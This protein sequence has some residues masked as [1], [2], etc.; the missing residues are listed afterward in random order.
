M[1]PVLR[2]MIIVNLLAVLGVAVAVWVAD[3]FGPSVDAADPPPAELTLAD[4]RG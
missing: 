2:S 1:T 4:G 3:P